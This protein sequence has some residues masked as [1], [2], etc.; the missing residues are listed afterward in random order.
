V[1][2]HDTPDFPWR[3]QHM[4]RYIA[5]RIIASIPVVMLVMVITFTLGYYAPG[6]PIE[7]IYNEQIAFMKPE[8]LVRLRHDFGLDRSYPEQAFDYIG[9]V[10]RGDLGTSIATKTP[11]LGMIMTGLP[12]TLQ[13]G[14]AALVLLV[15]AGIPLGVAAALRHNSWID[16]LIVGAVLGLRTIPIFVLAPIAM[17]VFV[18]QLG[19]L[20]VPIGWDGLFDAKVILPIL[21]LAAAPMAD[22][23]RQTRVAVLEVLGQD[24]IR[25]AHAKGLHLRMIV[26]RHILR[27]ALIP[28]VTSLGL[29]ANA[30]IHGS[31][32]LDRMFSLPGFGSL[33]V[34]GIQL[35]DFPVI[36]G[37]TIFSALIV[38]AANLITDVIYPFIDPRVRIE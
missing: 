19:W 18:L 38:I 14:F 35:L 31:V 29:I 34:N 1:S 9:K 3:E 22:V 28:V 30:L 15:V 37:T 5:G 32:F 16:Y 13:L 8:D 33:V 11:V 4:L 24:Y 27:N 21:L 36:L 26:V 10:T 2:F 25:T 23:V 12:I 6:D 7:L 20:D 17:I